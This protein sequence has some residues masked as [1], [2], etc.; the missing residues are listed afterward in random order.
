MTLFFPIKR[1][2]VILTGSYDNKKIPMIY[3]S[4]DIKLLEY[5]KK[6]NYAIL[7]KI[8]N[9]NTIYDNKLI[10][11]VITTSCFTPNLRPN[12]CEET[13]LFVIKLLSNWYGYPNINHN[14][15]VEFFFKIND[16]IQQYIEDMTIYSNKND[17][18]NNI[19]QHNDNGNDNNNIN[20]N[21][22]NGNNNI[23]KN[24][25]SNNSCFAT[26]I[27]NITNIRSNNQKSLKNINYNSTK[28]NYQ[29][30]SPIFII[31]V[32]ICVFLLL[33]ISFSVW[34]IWLKN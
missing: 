15:R 30:M 12:F 13:G 25:S 11:G 7:C 4:P 3:I 2:D 22:N 10:P 26:K 21:S 6:N 28:D 34:Y 17:V 9:T 18:I 31:L 20:N 27:D 29:G 23:T 8:S 16:K 24:N 33:L 19:G 32:S 1:W 14:G 5:A